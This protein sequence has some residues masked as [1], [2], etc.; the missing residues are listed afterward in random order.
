[1][2][3]K[4]IKV[5]CGESVQDLCRSQLHPVAEVKRAGELLAMACNVVSYSNSPDFVS[6]VNHLAKKYQAEP[7]FFLNGVSC[8]QDIEPIFADFN[9]AITMLKDANL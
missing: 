6:A 1:M 3:Q 8:G 2:S 5:Y 4:T 7:E 9:R